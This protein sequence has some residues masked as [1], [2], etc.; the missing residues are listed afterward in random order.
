MIV[1]AHQGAVNEEAI[2]DHELTPLQGIVQTS[3]LKWV[4]RVCTIISIPIP[5]SFENRYAACHGR[6]DEGRWF[7]TT[8]ATYRYS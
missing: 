8:L 3:T 6:T 1:A 2:R 7:W 4:V 5:A